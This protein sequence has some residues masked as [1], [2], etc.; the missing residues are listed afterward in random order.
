[1][2][3]RGS[4]FLPFPPDTVMATVRSEGDPGPLV[5]DTEQ[6]GNAASSEDAARMPDRLGH[7]I[8]RISI[9]PP[10]TDSGA[11]PIQRAPDPAGTTATPDDGAPQPGADGA[12]PLDAAKASSGSTTIQ[13]PP[14]MQSTTIHGTTLTAVAAALPDEAGSVDLDFSVATQGEPATA[15]TLNVTQT[16]TLPHWVERDKVSGAAQ[17]SWDRFLDALTQHESGHVA[18]D[19]RLFAN[20]H[21]RFVGIAAAQVG[22]TSSRLRAEVQAKQDEFDTQTDHG[23]KD[24]ADSSGYH[25]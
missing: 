21:Q 6:R 1:M 13:D 17:R 25:C 12:V 16:M 18:I 8:G 22:Q 4:S 9:L 24:S 11:L 3:H 23:R 20:G 14:T 10:R 2:Q 7:S 5:G 15:A 19:K